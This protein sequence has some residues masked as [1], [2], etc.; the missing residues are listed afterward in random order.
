MLTWFRNNAKIFL[1]VIVVI[2]VGMIFLNWGRGGLQSV[3]IDKLT[4]G[5]VNETGLQPAPRQCHRLSGR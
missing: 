4:V 1:I 2:F 5:S 3:E